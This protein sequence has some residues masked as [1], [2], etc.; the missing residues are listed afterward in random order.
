MLF[1]LNNKTL[2]HRFYYS[3]EQSRDRKGKPYH[4]LYQ[5]AMIRIV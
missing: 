5:T 4:N 1:P 3:L 2:K